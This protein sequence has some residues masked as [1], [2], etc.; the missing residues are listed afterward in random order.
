[1][2]R[3]CDLRIRSPLLYPAEL[4]GPRVRLDRGV[5]VPATAPAA[6]LT[7]AAPA[8]PVAAL[9]MAVLAA[10]LALDLRAAR[11]ASSG[12]ACAA[13]A[14]A[15]EPSSPGSLIASTAAFALSP[16]LPLLEAIDFS[17]SA[18][19]LRLSVPP[20][21][22]TR[23]LSLSVSFSQIHDHLS[24]P[25]VLAHVPLYPRFDPGRMR[26]CVRHRPPHLHPREGPSVAN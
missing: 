18:S 4:R 5:A 14:A 2:I 9:A 19:S 11:S 21:L 6:A 7:A 15:V 24:L 8:A 22:S 16:R 10:L 25:V 12:V 3:T 20:R 13:G 26:T 1:M 23:S 17:S